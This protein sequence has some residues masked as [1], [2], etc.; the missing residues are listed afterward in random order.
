MKKII[1]YSIYIILL[2]PFILLAADKDDALRES[3]IRSLE[4]KPDKDRLS[5]YD[6][7]A[8][9]VKAD[10]A[11]KTKTASS[12]DWT[13]DIATDPIDDSKKII[14]SKY[15]DE[16]LD[17]YSKPLLVLRYSNGESEA[18]ISWSKI[19]DY[20]ENENVTVILRFDKEEAISETW[21][22]SSGRDASFSTEPLSLIK[23]ILTHKTLIARTSGIR[24]TLTTQFDLNGLK[25][26][27]EKYDLELNWI[28]PKIEDSESLDSD[29]TSGSDIESEENT[30]TE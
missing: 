19:L 21:N 15:A 4:I 10:S 6:T 14:F 18:F 2:N 20:N 16:T 27:V 22:L 3:L 1:I 13:V 23:E 8:K 5:A 12:G 9:K 11:L 28:K 7:I 24:M 17:G 25:S 29:I 26:L 30:G